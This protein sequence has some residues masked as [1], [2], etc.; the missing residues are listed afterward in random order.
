MSSLNPTPTAV[1]ETL[2]AMISAP[3]PTTAQESEDWLR[4]HGIDPGTATERDPRGAGRA[5]DRARMADWGTADVGWGTF[6]EEFVGVHWFLWRGASS[7]DVMAGAHSLVD[8]LTQTQGPAADASESPLHGGTW[9]WL[10]P[11]HVIEAYAYHGLPR[12]DGFPAGDA[13]VQLHLGH[14]ERSEAQER[15]ARARDAQRR[16][17]PAGQ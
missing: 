6:R 11:G 14:R 13:C 7:E 8:L 16:P 10:L 9:L 3:W 15:E 4:E 5:W 17:G 1:A 12:P 2:L